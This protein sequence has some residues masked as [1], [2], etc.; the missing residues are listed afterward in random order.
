MFF[1]VVLPFSSR[2][3]LLAFCFGCS[4]CRGKDLCRQP[5]AIP[6]EHARDENAVT[7]EFLSR[8]GNTMPPPEF[9][10]VFMSQISHGN[11]DLKQPRRRAQWT[12]TGSVLTKPA[13]SAHVSDVVHMAFRT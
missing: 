3:W 8:V 1:S 12:T 13:T 5:L 6:V 4:L 9:A 11:R 10:H 2:F 7:M